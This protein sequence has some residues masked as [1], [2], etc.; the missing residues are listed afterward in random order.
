MTRHPLVF[1]FVAA[2]VIACRSAEDLQPGHVVDAPVDHPDG[3][4]E[5]DAGIK[6]PQDTSTDPD[7]TPVRVACTDTFGTALSTS[8]GRMDGI[9]V[10][11]VDPTNSGGN[12]RADDDHLH[13]QIRID[14]AVYDVAVNV[15]SDVLTTT[16]DMIVDATAWSEGWH[17]FDG[18]DY[19][20]VGVHSDD[21]VTP[22]SMTEVDADLAATNHITIYGTGFDPTGAHL[23][24][25][26]NGADGAIVTH[27]LSS[28]PHVRM[29]RFSNQS[30]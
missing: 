30:F 10:S 2:S 12:C 24:H 21:I 13:L 28:P 19:A 16:R 15:G 7:G 8:Y 14:G 20:T 27:P 23:I 17:P 11:V 26:N 3:D 5:I 29:F 18:F 6:P 22:L 4:V 1:V 9:L 25:R